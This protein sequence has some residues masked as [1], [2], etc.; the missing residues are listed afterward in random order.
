MDW[1]AAVSGDSSRTTLS[2]PLKHAEDCIGESAIKEI[3]VDS[4]LLERTASS[5]KS[6]AL[7]ADELAARYTPEA[8]DRSFIGGWIAA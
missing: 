7:F 2:E 1:N 8:G 3:S 4:I 6:D 5:R